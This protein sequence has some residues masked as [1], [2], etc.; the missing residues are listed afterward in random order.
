MVFNQEMFLA[1]S[2]KLT[3]IVMRRMNR[4]H[5]CSFHSLEESQKKKFNRILN[6]YIKD[7][8]EGKEEET[9]TNEFNQIVNE[10][11]LN[12]EFRAESEFVKEIK[13]DTELLLTDDQR[14][15]LEEE[16]KRREAEGLPRYLI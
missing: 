5:T 4:K 13:T 1:N 14:T 7:L 9:I 15:Y 12:E 10:D 11:I 8:E 16:N 2:I 3:V 6:S